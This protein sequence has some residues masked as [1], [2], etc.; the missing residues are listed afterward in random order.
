MNTKIIKFDINKNLYD[1]LIAKQG[2]TKSR[3]L[4]FNL[5]DG[6]IPFSLENRSVRV[7][8]I[9]PDGT[10]V[11]NDLIITD[12]T[13]G[14]CILELT[15]QILA[16]AGTVKLELMVI[17]NEKKL[18]SNIFYMSVKESINSEKAIVSTNEFGALLTALSSLNEYDNYKKEIAAARDGEANLLTKVKKIDEQLDTKIR[19]VN[20]VAELKTEDLKVNEIIKTL[21]Y[22]SVGDGGGSYYN[23]INE[24]LLENDID[25]IS[26][27]NNLVA[28]LIVDT[29]YVEG[30]QFGAKTGSLSTKKERIENKN[31]LQRCIDFAIEN[32]IKLVKFEQEYRVETDNVDEYAINISY[33]E[34]LPK[35][36]LDIEMKCYLQC[37]NCNGFLIKNLSNSNLNISLAY[38][39]YSENPEL[40][41]GVTILN[42]RQLN[43]NVNGNNYNGT[44]IRVGNSQNPVNLCTGKINCYGGYRCLVHGDENDTSRQQFFGTY[45]TVFYDNTTKGSLIINSDDIHFKHFENKFS[46]ANENA[47]E[48]INSTTRFSYIG[49]G[50]TCNNN[51]LVNGVDSISTCT[52]DKLYLASKGNSKGVAVTGNSQLNINFFEDSGC[53]ILLDL[54][55]LVGGSYVNIDNIFTKKSQGERITVR[56][57]NINLNETMNGGKYRLILNG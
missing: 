23:I 44:L 31:R 2:D 16:V 54:Y 24:S 26:C 34:L 6:S 21:G 1:T 53:R 10:E 45:E 36:C 49:L 37:Y 43:F 52:I 25:I 51:I 46:Q 55:S 15:T 30:K 13:K 41:T 50:D 42:S 27:K 8:A 32:N 57:D 18:T 14:Y 38:G 48:I 47:L 3:F 39:G 35:N 7:Y 40:V 17:E 9:K 29:N 4:L 11:F 56:K 28:K 20:T 22:Y 12:A 19:Y 5:L 33:S